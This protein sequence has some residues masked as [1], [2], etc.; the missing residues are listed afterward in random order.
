VLPAAG[1]QYLLP[2][3]WTG[4]LAANGTLERLAQLLSRAPAHLVGLGQHKGS[5]AAGMDADFVVRL[6]A[7]LVPS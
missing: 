3:T 6:A 5:I 1:L 7:L 2:A 4:L